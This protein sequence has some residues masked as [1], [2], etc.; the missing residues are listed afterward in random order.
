MGLFGRRKAAEQALGTAQAEL[1]A[2]RGQLAA[3]E[4]ARR[5][6]AAERDRLR[7]NGDDLR[8]TVGRQT[9]EI[10]AAERAVAEATAREAATRTQ[11]LAEGGPGPSWPLVLADMQRRWANTVG[12]Q[13]ADRAM[14]ATD[15]PGQL[16]EALD[17]EVERVREEVGVDVSIVL[18]GGIATPQPVVYLLAATDL[19]GAM[20]STFERVALEVDDGLVM[21]GEVWSELGD[22]LEVA[23]QRA[24]DAG[25]AVDPVE[26]DEER[27][28]VT[29]RS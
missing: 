13:P 14:K 26:V 22:D 5:E 18:S 2:L 29:L 25:L 3:G 9:A 10:E 1:Q 4:S 6:L 27:V 15:V 17:R 28:R 20:V 12:V 7:Q 21:V 8:A 24:V 23:R 11:A 19:L 16:A